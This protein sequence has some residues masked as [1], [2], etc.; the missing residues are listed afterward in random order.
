M[1]GDKITKEQARVSLENYLV[2]KA[3][4][5]AKK[6]EIKDKLPGNWEDLYCPDELKGCFFAHD[7]ADDHSYVRASRIIAISK[8]TGEIVSDCINPAKKDSLFFS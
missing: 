7:I 8:K 1:A 5:K 2:K 6:L 3:K 4:K